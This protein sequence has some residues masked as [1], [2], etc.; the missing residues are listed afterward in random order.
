MEND[1]RT[2]FFGIIDD[3]R[4]GIVEELMNQELRI[5]GDE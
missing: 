4:K 1:K 2:E 5:M 3:D